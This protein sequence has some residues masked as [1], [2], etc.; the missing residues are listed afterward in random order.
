MG[1]IVSANYLDRNSEYKWMVR[2]EDDSN[3]LEFLKELNV[4]DVEFQPAGK[5]EVAHGCGTIAYTTY[6]MKST[7]SKIVT[8]ITNLLRLR[9]QNNEFVR[10]DN[11]QVVRECKLLSLRSDGSMYAEIAPPQAAKQKAKVEE[12]QHTEVAQSAA[13]EVTVSVSHR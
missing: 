11:G 10:E 2:D 1:K 6:K 3:K 12:D 13:E 8:N 9:F 7:A 4:C 5:V